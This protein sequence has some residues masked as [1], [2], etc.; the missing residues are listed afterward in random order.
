MDYINCTPNK[1]YATGH[2]QMS[3]LIM[4]G[5]STPMGSE[6]CSGLSYSREVHVY[7][8]ETSGVAP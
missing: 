4:I 2:L 1:L 7:A 5:T 3:A 6:K 8:R